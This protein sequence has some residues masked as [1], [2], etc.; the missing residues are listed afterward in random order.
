MGARIDKISQICRLRPRSVR[1]ASTNVEIAPAVAVGSVARC[2]GNVLSV[3]RNDPLFCEFSIDRITQVLGLEKSAS[4]ESRPIVCL[5][6]LR[7]S[8]RLML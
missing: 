5:A 2:K 8:L 4:V 6:L 7:V 1:L 3:G